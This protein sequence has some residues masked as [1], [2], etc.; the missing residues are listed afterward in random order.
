M[1]KTQYN[2]K[3][4]PEKAAE[5][6]NAIIS[7]AHSLIDDAELLYEHG[8][9]ERAAALS[10]LAVEEAG[11]VSIIRSILMEDDQKNLT[12]NGKGLEIT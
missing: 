5:G 8:R 7:N 11:K 9:Y 1:K 2:Q 6:I 3:L 4:T 10:I 12:K